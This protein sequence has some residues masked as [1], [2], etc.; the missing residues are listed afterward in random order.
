MRYLEIS[1][2]D[3]PV[4]IIGLGTS[5]TAFT[6][7]GNEATDLLEEFLAA[8]GN[9]VDT[10]HIYG[11]GKSEQTLGSWLEE[12]GR[13]SE[14]I[15]ITK[16]CHPTVDPD[17]VFGKPWVSR[18]TPEAI[19][20]DLSESL[21][22]LRTDHVDLYLLHRDD[23]T[24]DPGPLMETLTEEQERGRIKVFGA[25]NWSVERI[26][27]A[28]AFAA[29]NGLNGFAVSS[30][31]LS[32]ARP[33]VMRYPGTLFADDAIRQWHQTTGFPLLAWSAQ[34]AGLLLGQSPSDAPDDAR[35]YI[36]DENFE[37]LRRAQELGEAKN[38]TGLQVA[39]AYVLLQPFPVVGLVGPS[40]VSH[41]EEAL[42]GLDVDLTP[43]EIEY[44]DLERA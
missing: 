18:V 9:L 42:G 24:V 21:E 27:E 28:N 31:G 36:S 8:G 22:R 10:A 40:S 3:T 44:L 14:V 13:R 37:R 30:Q 32:L 6:T 25:S 7:E 17:D 19:R 4:S 5:T 29:R 1:G 16:G 20:A 34:S 43:E 11:V 2:L 33:T 23:E 41:L 12:S 38:A 39:L 15:L 35:A 26:A